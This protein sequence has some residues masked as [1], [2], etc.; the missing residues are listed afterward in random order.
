[1]VKRTNQHLRLVFKVLH[2][3]LSQVQHHVHPHPVRQLHLMVVAI[4]AQQMAIV[5]S[6]RWLSLL[7]AVT[8]DDAIHFHPQVQILIQLSPI[9][10]ELFHIN[11]QQ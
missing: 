10:V 4:P 6:S 3:P 5:V 1:M 2:H 7:I 9:L 11:H 8:M